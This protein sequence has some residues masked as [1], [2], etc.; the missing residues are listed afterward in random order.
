MLLKAFL[1]PGDIV[2]DAAGVARES[3]HAQVLRSFVNMIVWGAVSVGLTV[4]W[5][6]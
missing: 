2:C 5:A 3:D 1:L 4:W 6:A